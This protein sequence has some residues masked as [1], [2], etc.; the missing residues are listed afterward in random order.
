MTSVG[1]ILKDWTDKPGTVRVVVAVISGRMPS[2]VDLRSPK[3]GS[4]SE[5]CAFYGGPSHW[6]ADTRKDSKK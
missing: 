3:N 1:D 6:P 4:S 2:P 5:T